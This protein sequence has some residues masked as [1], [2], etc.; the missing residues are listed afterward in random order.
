MNVRSIL[1]KLS[2]EFSL[3]DLTIL[4]NDYSKIL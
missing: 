4:N 3:N 2:T 1:F